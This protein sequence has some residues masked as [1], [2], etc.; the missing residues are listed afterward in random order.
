MKASFHPITILSTIPS[1]GLG[2]LLALR[3]DASD[4]TIIAIIGVILLIGM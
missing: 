4:L 3:S 1:A 2:A